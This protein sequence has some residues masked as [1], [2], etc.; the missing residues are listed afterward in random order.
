MKYNINL[1]K[2]RIKFKVLYLKW[3][4]KEIGVDRTALTTEPKQTYRDASAEDR[5][6]L[7]QKTVARRWRLWPQNKDRRKVSQLLMM[8]LQ[9][10]EE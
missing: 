9:L 2:K 7:K 3:K 4:E 1:I 5:K 10:I 6:W 8:V